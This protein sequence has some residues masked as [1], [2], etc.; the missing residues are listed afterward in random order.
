MAHIISLLP[1]DAEYHA[2]ALQGVYAATPGYWQMYGLEGPP[3]DQAQQDL[4]A[5]LAAPLRD[6]RP[7]NRPHSR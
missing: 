7:K 3:P 2:P 4:A 1:L 5:A 6:R